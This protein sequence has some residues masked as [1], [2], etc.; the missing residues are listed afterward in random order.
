[1]NLSTRNVYKINYSSCALVGEY[2]HSSVEVESALEN[3]LSIVLAYFF[4][5]LSTL[6]DQL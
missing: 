5:L 6:S 3:C 2:K 1:M 4:V